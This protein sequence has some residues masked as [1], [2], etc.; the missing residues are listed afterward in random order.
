MLASDRHTALADALADKGTPLPPTPN[1]TARRMSCRAGILRARC[2]P[3]R[4][5]DT[6]DGEQVFR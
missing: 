6:S 1:S 3:G 5:L 4:S 2:S